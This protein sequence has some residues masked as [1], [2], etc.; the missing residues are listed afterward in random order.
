MDG[1]AEALK[2]LDGLT[3]KTLHVGFHAGGEVLGGHADAE[4]LDA[5]P[6]G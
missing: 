4:A 5:V 6:D 3:D 1:C 2:G